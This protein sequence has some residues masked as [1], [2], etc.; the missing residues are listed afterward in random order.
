MAK[1]VEELR[2]DRGCRRGASEI[3]ATE[4]GNELRIY[5]SFEDDA[6]RSSARRMPPTRIEL[7]HA[8]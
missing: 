5:A 2:I 6:R 1:P 8:V 7:V 4:R 3:V